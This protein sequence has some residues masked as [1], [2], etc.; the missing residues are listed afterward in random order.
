MLLRPTRVHNPNDMSIGSAIL[1]L[2]AECRR[3]CP[4][5]FFPLKIAPWYG[6]IWTLSNAWFLGP[7][8][9][10]TPNGISIGSAVFAGSPIKNGSIV[11]ARLRQCAPHVTRASLGPPQSTT[12]TASGSVRSFVHSPRQCRQTCPVMSFRLNI[13]PSLGTIWTHI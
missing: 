2:T 8:R 7:T 13:A 6:A 11:F 4:D 5:M 1:K 9:V 12:Q 3:A 10:H